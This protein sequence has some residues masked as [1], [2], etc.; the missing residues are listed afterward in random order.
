[1]STLAISYLT[2][3]NLPWFMDLTFKVHMQC[4]S[5]QHQTL[6]SLPVTSTAGHCFHFGSASS[7]LLEL[8]VHP[9]PVALWGTYW[10]LKFISAMSS[11]QRYVSPEVQCHIFLSFHTV[12]GILQARML[13]WFAIPFSN[14]PCFVGTVHHDSSVLTSMAHIFID[15]DKAVTH[16][17]TLV[18]FLW[19]RFSFCLPSDGWGWG[20]ISVLRTEKV[21]SR[22][23]K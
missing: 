14:G 23:V 6:L 3:S 4:I 19:L 1:M 12:H 10:P 20:Y 18:S 9:S 2:T 16:V 22:S 17:I 21:A 8:F 5:L 11:C 13:K 15:L 7:F